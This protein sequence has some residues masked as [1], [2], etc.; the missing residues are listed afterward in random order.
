MK[1]IIL[2]TAEAHTL[3]DIRSTSIDFLGFVQ[4]LEIQNSAGR[5]P[6]PCNCVDYV[7]LTSLFDHRVPPLQRFQEPCRAAVPEGVFA[8]GLRIDLGSLSKSIKRPIT[9]PKSRKTSIKKPQLIYAFELRKGINGRV[10]I[11]EY[12]YVKDAMNH[13]YM[14]FGI[15]SWILKLASVIEIKK[16]GN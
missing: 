12:K 13:H 2:S 9:Y 15:K 3:L 6:F 16:N 8:I 4:K 14:S 11:A 10:N 1:N 5:V 7:V